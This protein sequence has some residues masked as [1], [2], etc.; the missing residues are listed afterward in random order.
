MF[1][2]TPVGIIVLDIVLV[3]IALLIG[4]VLIPILIKIFRQLGNISSDLTS[5][6]KAL[7]ATNETMAN[8]LKELQDARVRDKELEG[9][10]KGIQ[11]DV[12]ELRRTQQ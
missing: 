4:A 1:G 12:E 8:V 10:M 11:S 2:D 5:C 9:R 3:V 6:F 7:T